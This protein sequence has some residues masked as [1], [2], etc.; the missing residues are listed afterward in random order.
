[1]AE[2]IVGNAHVKPLVVVALGM[3]SA[4]YELGWAL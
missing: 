1:M 2:E 4:W 3:R